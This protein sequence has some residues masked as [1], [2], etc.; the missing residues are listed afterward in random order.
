MRQKPNSHG[1]EAISTITEHAGGSFTDA[2]SPLPQITSMD[3]FNDVV[4]RAAG[5]DGASSDGYEDAQ[6]NLRIPHKLLMVEIHAGWCRV[7]KG[8][9]PKLLKLVTKHPE[10]LCCKINKTSNEVNVLICTP[11]SKRFWCIKSLPTDALQ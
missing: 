6:G 11:A 4:S 9:Q 5:A 1:H 2:L 3:H 10:V 7:C 8:L